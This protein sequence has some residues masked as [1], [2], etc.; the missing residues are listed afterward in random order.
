MAE[1]EAMDTTFEAAMAGFLHEFSLSGEFNSPVEGA[2]GLCDSDTLEKTPSNST[3]RAKL[4][5]NERRDRYRKRLQNERESLRRQERELSVKLSQL[6][7]AQAKAKEEA[8]KSNT[9]ALSAWRATAARQK[10]KRLEAEQE[11]QRLKA[12]VLDRAELIRQLSALMMMSAP[13][14]SL[15]SCVN[16]ISSQEMQ[17]AL[18]YKTF[19]RE[20]D[21]LYA[22]TAD[23]VGGVQ[24]D[25]LPPESFEVRRRWNQD[26]TLMESADA[27]QISIPFDQTWRS[28]SSLYLA[29]PKGS[30]YRGEIHDRENTAAVTY[31]SNYTLESGTTTLITYSSVRRYVEKDCVVFVWRSQFEGQGE[32]DGVFSDEHAWLVI[33][34]SDMPEGPGT[35][36]QSYTQLKL[37]DLDGKMGTNDLRGNQFVKLVGM[38]DEEDMADVEEAMQGLLIGESQSGSPASSDV[39]EL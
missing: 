28:L 32:F 17:G 15:A 34:P 29:D 33:R 30:H 4:K 24:C 25:L 10:G 20:L 19:M 13:M 3:D 31:R 35:T 39:M 6:L 8:K 11:Q 23:L 38:V 7:T 9:L 2:F 12:A 22:K 16:P 27:T 14:K 18:L 36:L 5:A 26:K 21:Y 37:T 1:G